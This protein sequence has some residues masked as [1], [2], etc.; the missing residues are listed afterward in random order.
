[1][2]TRI[3]DTEAVKIDKRCVII[4]RIAEEEHKIDGI[5]FIC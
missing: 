4:I 1:M 3:A 2:D 5:Y